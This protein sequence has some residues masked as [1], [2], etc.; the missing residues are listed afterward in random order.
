MKQKALSGRSEACFSDTANDSDR[1]IVLKKSVSSGD[2]RTRGKSTSQN[3]SQST[4]SDRD[5][6]LSDMG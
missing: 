3:A 2:S 4:I 1:S 6:L 5:D